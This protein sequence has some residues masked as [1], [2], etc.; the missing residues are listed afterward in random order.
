MSCR[1]PRQLL[2]KDHEISSD[3]EKPHEASTLSFIPLNYSVL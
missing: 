3:K 1:V 2:N